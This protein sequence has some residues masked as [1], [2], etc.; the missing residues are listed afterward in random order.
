MKLLFV[1]LGLFL[2]FLRHE[3][4][5][6]SHLSP[7]EAPLTTKAQLYFTYFVDLQACCVYGD[8]LTCL[9]I[10]CVDH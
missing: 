4:I 5:L 1:L 3:H 7:K 2:T 8:R 10:S 6:T 9:F